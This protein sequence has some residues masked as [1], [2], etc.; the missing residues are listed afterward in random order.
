MK[1]HEPPFIL[2]TTEICYYK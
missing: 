1:I 2:E